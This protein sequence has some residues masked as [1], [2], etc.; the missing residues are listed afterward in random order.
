MKD[1]S[2][3]ESISQSQDYGSGSNTWRAP[4][5]WDS[6]S[7]QSYVAALQTSFEWEKH[8]LYSLLPKM[9]EHLIDMTLLYI[10]KAIL[11]SILRWVF[12]DGIKFLMCSAVYISKRPNKIKPNWSRS[13]RFAIRIEFCY[14]KQTIYRT[15]IVCSDVIFSH[16][17]YFNDDQLS[18]VRWAFTAFLVPSYYK[19]KRNSFF[20]WLGA[21]FYEFMYLVE[22]YKR[23]PLTKIDRMRR[24][25]ENQ[26]LWKQAHFVSYVWWSPD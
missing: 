16:S 4:V 12:A 15:T 8:E 24:A 26:W 6:S 20:V 9:I 13:N 1:S 2:P 5:S 11:G 3:W 23:A 7:S 17:H 21:P 25:Q 19:V 22:S 18:L 14:E 10:I